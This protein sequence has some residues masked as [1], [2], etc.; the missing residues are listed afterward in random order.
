MDR[1]LRD[2]GLSIPLQRDWAAE[3][4]LL[5][6]VEGLSRIARRLKPRAGAP[7]TDWKSVFYGN[8]RC[9]VI[10]SELSILL[11]VTCSK[12][13]N[14]F[15]GGR[16]INGSLSAWHWI[17]DP[18]SVGLGGRK[19]PAGPGWEP[20]PD[21]PAVETAGWR[22]SNRLDVGFPFLRGQSISGIK[23]EILSPS[24][25]GPDWF[26]SR[27]GRHP[28][29]CELTERIISKNDVNYVQ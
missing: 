15:G 1:S 9:S 27:S 22:S 11:K 7:Q 8:M 28:Q 29:E 16:L 18:A 10:S 19:Q 3:N 2:T 26:S 4:S 17:V 14:K 25:C 5:G 20:F 21:R 24:S 6:R 12:F 23:T 13:E